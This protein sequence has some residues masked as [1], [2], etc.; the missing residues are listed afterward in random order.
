MCW[1]GQE[2][3]GPAVPVGVGKTKNENEVWSL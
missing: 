1:V 2:S 3:F